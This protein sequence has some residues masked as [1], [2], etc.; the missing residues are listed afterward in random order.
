MSGCTQRTQSLCQ[1][2]HNGHSRYVRV[3]T[4]DTVVMSGCTQR[5]L[6][7]YVRVHTTDTV[8][9]S[10]CMQRTLS[11][12]VRVHTTDTVVMS[13]CI[14]R[15][16]SRYVRVHTT[17]THTLHR[18][19]RF[20]V[21]VQPTVQRPAGREKGPESSPLACLAA[22]F[23]DVPTVTACVV[24]LLGWFSLPPPLPP[25][26]RQAPSSAMTP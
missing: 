2:A 12:H 25:P 7:R 11:R 19:H 18:V 5:T 20:A 3:Y 1:G 23:A 4:M 21:L 26:P 9:M 13:G 16:L 14:Q 6:S 8:V 24:L 17:D 22:L 15:T 10:G